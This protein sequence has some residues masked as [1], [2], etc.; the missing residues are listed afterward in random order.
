[1]AWTTWN[2][3]VETIAMRLDISEQD[4]AHMIRAANAHDDLIAT[5]QQIANRECEE[6]EEAYMAR[7]A[8]DKAGVK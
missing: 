2:P 5:L 1:M 8:L 4:A 7:A 6:G 3:D